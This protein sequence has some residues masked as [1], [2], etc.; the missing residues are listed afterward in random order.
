[1]GSGLQADCVCPLCKEPLVAR[2]G[3]KVVH[4]F[5]HYS[6]S[7]CKPETVLHFIAK[8]LLYR[9]IQKAISE[10]AAIHMQWEC[11][12]CGRNHDG[13]LLKKATRVE[14]ELNL[15]ACRPDLALLDKTGK[16]IAFIEIIVT[17][18][19]G[20][21]V[22]AYCRANRVAIIEFDVKNG[23]DLE[24]MATEG[25]RP[26]RVNQCD[27]KVCEQCHKPVV[28]KRLVVV[29]AKCWRCSAPQKVT[30]R[31]T[32]TNFLQ[33]PDCFT[34][35]ER[36]LAQQKG[37]LLRENYS[38]SWKKSYLTNTCGPCG[39]FIGLDHLKEYIIAGLTGLEQ[40][41][42]PCGYICPQCYR[43]YSLQMDR[44]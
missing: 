3:I 22:L 36:A 11:Q 26:N 8:L 4:H 2:K 33:N 34:R 38:N 44:E 6:G 16:V 12:R 7:N 39:A 17:H 40:I 24:G 20:E 30:Y 1:M 41:G 42:T 14:L 9:K 25:F 21:N 23:A 27:C 10:N 19:P 43:E 5:A 28:M 29:D 35:S 37:V 32:G 15:S 18:S 31:E 13:N